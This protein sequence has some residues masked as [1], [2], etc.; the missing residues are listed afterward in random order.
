LSQKA[1]R[2]RS[3]K[4]PSLDGYA[5]LPEIEPRAK[6]IALS[7]DKCHA[8]MEEKFAK[9]KNERYKTE[10]YSVRLMPRWREVLLLIFFSDDSALQVKLDLDGDRV[11]WV[12]NYLNGLSRPKGN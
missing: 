12:K 5:E 8:M 2:A 1:L 10:V 3:G 6:R 11:I 4:L 9:L 7:Y